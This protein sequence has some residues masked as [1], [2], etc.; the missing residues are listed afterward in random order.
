MSSLT[1]ILEL[2]SFLSTKQIIVGLL[3]TSGIIAI[4]EVWLLSLPALLGQYLLI[5]LLL[6][7]FIRPEMATAKA[8]TGGVSCFILLLTA[9]HAGW[10]GDPRSKTIPE[11]WAPGKQGLSNMSLFFRLFVFILVG[12]AAYGLFVTYPLQGVAEDINFACYWLTLMGFLAVVLN[13]AP[14]PVGLG[15]LTFESGFEVLYATLEESLTVA[16]L[17]A[18]VNILAALAIAYLASMRWE[19]I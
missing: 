7:R 11:P 12:I 15:I 6:S 13:R 17:L 1:Q 5:G 2:L 16:G 18:T 14:L 10:R 19:E 9:W 4:I 8:I 3:F